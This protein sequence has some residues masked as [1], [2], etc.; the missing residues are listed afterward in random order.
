MQLGLQRPFHQ[1]QQGPREVSVLG[2]PQGPC[3][4]GVHTRLCLY[5]FV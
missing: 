4:Q 3:A 5:L 2:V 1:G